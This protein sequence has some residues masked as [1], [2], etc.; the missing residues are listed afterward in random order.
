MGDIALD[1]E[2]LQ[3]LFPTEYERLVRTSAQN[4][5]AHFADPTAA[6][7]N[8]QPDAN[9]RASRRLGA[10]PE[11]TTARGAR[12]T[13]TVEAEAKARREREEEEEKAQ[14]EKARREKERQTT[15]A[16]LLSPVASPPARRRG[17]ALIRRPG[18]RYSTSTAH[19][20]TQCAAKRM[21][22][23]IAQ[24][25]PPRRPAALLL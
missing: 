6:H 5:A 7:A 18:M 10:Q 3:T 8:P 14:E 4:R 21:Y 20:L 24:R 16:P 9:A 13:K 17:A 12:A 22:T 25:T 11:D 23:I 2:D 15:T 19:T 1:E